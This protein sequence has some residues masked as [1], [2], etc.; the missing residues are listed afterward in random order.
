MSS[1]CQKECKCLVRKTWMAPTDRLKEANTFERMDFCQQLLSWNKMGRQLKMYCCM[2]CFE[3]NSLL[4][5]KFYYDPVKR[6]CSQKVQYREKTLR[7]SNRSSHWEVFSKKRCSF[8]RGLHIVDIDWLVLN[9]NVFLAGHCFF[10]RS[11]N[12]R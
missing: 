4:W 1:C 2:R 11:F 7:L 10:P 6:S 3:K 5:Q 8:L 12:Q 9:E